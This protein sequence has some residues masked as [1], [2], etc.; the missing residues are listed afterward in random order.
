[1]ES[2]G[3]RANII[4]CNFVT[5]LG[6]FAALNA[7][8]I[9]VL[10]KQQPTGSIKMNEVLELSAN[11]YFNADQMHLTFDLDADFNP[12][13]NWNTNQLFLYVTASYMTTANK[14]N[15]VTVWDYILKDQAN[16]RMKLRKERNEYPLRDQFKQLRGRNVTLSLKYRYMPIVGFMTEHVVATSSF[17]IPDKYFKKNK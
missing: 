2:Y 9:N 16:A 3:T 5:C 1:M 7:C 4:F 14:R 6:V 13:M 10:T 12:V 15:E 8:S 11:T 17:R